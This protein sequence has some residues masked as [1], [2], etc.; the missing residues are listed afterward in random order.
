[1]GRRVDLDDLIDAGGV[2]ELIGLTHRN[3]VYSYRR[4]YPD[5]P[6]PVI[7]HGRCY[8]WHRGDIRRWIKTRSK[9]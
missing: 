9:R 4:K 7:T 5:F 6:A 8:M 2:A 1:M 3:N